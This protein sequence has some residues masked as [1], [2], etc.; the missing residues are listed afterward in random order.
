MGYAG[1]SA[2]GTSVD[3]CAQGP[4]PGGAGVFNAHASTLALN[5]TRASSLVVTADQVIHLVPIGGGPGARRRSHFG[6]ARWGEFSAR[7]Q[8]GRYTSAE[9]LIEWP[10]YVPVEFGSS[11]WYPVFR[12][13]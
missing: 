6:L 13:G 1:L 8:A 11:G 9:P 4:A 2:G 10:T 12:A 7:L 3:C 5:L